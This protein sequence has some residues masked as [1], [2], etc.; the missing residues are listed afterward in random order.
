MKKYLLS[1]VLVVVMMSSFAGGKKPKYYIKVKPEHPTVV[2]NI[3][4]RP[5]PQHVWVDGYWVWRPGPARY[6]WVE[7]SWV[8]P[9]PKHKIWVPGHW[10]K[11]RYGWYWQEG[12]WQ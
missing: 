5:S 1:I 2:V 12:H 4:P 9:P 3:G 8:L 7:G 6:E 11:V 10:R